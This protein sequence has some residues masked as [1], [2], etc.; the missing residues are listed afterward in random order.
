MIDS[1][2]LVTIGTVDVLIDEVLRMF[3][4]HGLHIHLFNKHF[5]NTR[6]NS[7]T[8]GFIPYST[9]LYVGRT[10]VTASTT[11]KIRLVVIYKLVQIESG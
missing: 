9:I 11:N 8:L 5:N 2:I 6:K 3:D 4:V 7:N 10:G 1:I